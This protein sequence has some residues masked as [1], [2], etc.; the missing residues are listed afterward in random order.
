MTKGIDINNLLNVRYRA[1]AGYGL[2]SKAKIP[3]KNVNQTLYSN[4]FTEKWI[5]LGVTTQD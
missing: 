3:E 5:D 2:S 4:H 1:K